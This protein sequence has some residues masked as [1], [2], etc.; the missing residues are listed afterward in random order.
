[1]DKWQSTLLA[2]YAEAIHGGSFAEVTAGALN[3]EKGEFGWTLYQLQMRGMI[4]GCKFQPPE[5]GSAGNLMGVIRS[6]LLLT[7]KGFETAEAMTAEET[8]AG[9][10]NRLWS[11][12]RDVGCGVMAN[13]IYGW[14]N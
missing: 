8:D 12:L 13:I 4:E 10:L 6:G 2:L 7:P 5:P 11:A 1:M 14:L 3:M 9:R